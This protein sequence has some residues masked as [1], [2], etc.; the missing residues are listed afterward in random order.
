MEQVLDTHLDG[1]ATLTVTLRPGPG[2]APDHRTVA[3]DV[4]GVESVEQVEVGG[5]AMAQP[6]NHPVR[7]TDELL[8]PAL[9]VRL[10]EVDLGSVVAVRLG[11]ARRSPR[12]VAGDAFALIDAAEIEFTAKEAAWRA[13]TGLSGWAMVQQLATVDIPSSL[14]DALVEVA[15]AGE[16]W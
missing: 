13:V 14:R 6:A 2:A 11:G 1:T 9:R 5:G 8:A 15:A 4:V 3:L 16:V 7:T 12:D 10:G